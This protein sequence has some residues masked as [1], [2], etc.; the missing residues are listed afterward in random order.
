MTRS[1]YW[2]KIKYCK[3]SALSSEVSS[4][5]HIVRGA[6]IVIL[7]PILILGS[8]L[9]GNSNQ[10]KGDSINVMPSPAELIEEKPIVHLITINGVI[11]TILSDYLAKSIQSAEEKEV[12][13]IIIQLDTPGGL[14]ES[15]R[16]IVKLELRADI[17]I[18]VY[19]GP[20]GARAASAG[21]FIT[22]AAHFAIM[23]P[24]SNIGAAHPVALP[25]ISGNAPDTS[26][27]MMDKVI[28]DAV[29]YLQSIGEKRGRNTDWAKSAILESASITAMEALELGVIDTV[30]SSI[31]EILL[32]LDGKE[33]EVLSG[34]RT[35][36][37]KN[38][39]VVP[40]E[41]GLRYRILEVLTNP[42]IAYLLLLLGF[43]GV[44][45]ELSNPGGF[46][47]GILGVLSLILAFL[48]FQLLPINYAGLALL[49]LGIIMFILELKVTS[50]GL[51]SIGGAISMS[52]GS[53]MLFESPDPIMRVSL[54][55]MIPAILFTVFFF[56]FAIGFAIK[57]QKRK[58]V[59][60]S[61]S[62]LD[63]LGEAKTNISPSG[64]V[65][66]NGEIWRAES[67]QKIKAG[68]L[69][70]VIGVNGL[71]L[72]IKR[73]SPKAKQEG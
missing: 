65:L 21:V 9:L 15:M 19:V 45:F 25:G 24:S 64:Q 12:A 7:V 23:N 11:G 43:Y 34:S 10:E 54:E 2:N 60:G 53:L 22:M 44:F 1:S 51:L 27:V 33:T 61:E 16:D 5:F 58:A 32:Y 8:S 17:P 50:F 72:Q 48:A 13:C 66:I 69:I 4:L 14:M 70:Q 56:V 3:L 49:V 20:A 26:S 63:L 37:L 62:M 36:S 46:F 31:Q 6:V 42:N 73:S 40:I 52:L 67:T 59:T 28:N 18:I 29:A 57:A 35:L 55:V 38:A 71:V 30:A 39:E 68:E 41:M 47:P